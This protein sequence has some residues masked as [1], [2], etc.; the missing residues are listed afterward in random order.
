MM[1]KP[2]STD[3]ALVSFVSSRD[4]TKRWTV[5]RGEL[6]NIWCDCPGWMF[7]KVC[8]H[9][10]IVHTRGL[11]VAE[12]L[13]NTERIKAVRQALVKGVK[14]V[15]MYSDDETIAR[16]VAALE[17]EEFMRAAPRKPIKQ[18]QRARL[19]TLPDEE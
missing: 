9:T 7:R 10:R 19:I 17:R 14:E 4:K 11:D 16:F 5:F 2:A 12:S 1:T 15:S 6:G 3:V 8:K 13:S 18:G